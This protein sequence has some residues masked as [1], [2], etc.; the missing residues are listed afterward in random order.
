[1]GEAADATV[2]AMSGQPKSKK[3][4]RAKKKAAKKKTKK[5][6]AKKKSKKRAAK[7]KPAD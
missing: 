1:M 5:K 6:A 2:T 7:K 4:L 3:E